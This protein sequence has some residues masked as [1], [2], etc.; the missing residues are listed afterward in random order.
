MWRG[1]GWIFVAIGGVGVFVPL[2]PTVPFMLLAA[3]CFERGSPELHQWIMQHKVF[4]PQLRAWREH[5]VI[6][7]RAKVLSVS[8][9]TLSVTY[10]LCTRGMPLGLALVIVATCL[11]T[12]GFILIQKGKI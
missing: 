12:A 5:R 11:G 1:L 8:C 7:V 6:G 9:I 2:L 10:V 4:G 3:F